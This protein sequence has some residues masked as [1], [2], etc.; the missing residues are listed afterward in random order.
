VVFLPLYIDTNPDDGGCSFYVMANA[1]SYLAFIT[2][3]LVCSDGGSKSE[4]ALV[5]DE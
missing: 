5:Q 4:E 2:S 1:H 3:G